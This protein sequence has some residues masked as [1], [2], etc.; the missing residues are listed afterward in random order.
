[1]ATDSLIAPATMPVTGLTCQ[2]SGRCVRH[3]PGHNYHG[4]SALR[5]VRRNS[6]GG[7]EYADEALTHPIRVLE[8]QACA[9]AS[10][11]FG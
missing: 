10:S 1:M 11:V 5:A 8:P 7:A 6:G 4:G 9:I 3:G 2:N